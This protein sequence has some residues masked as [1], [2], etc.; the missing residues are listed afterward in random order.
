MPLYEY[1]C[2][3]C[4]GVLETLQR[5][6]DAPLT[7]HENCGGALKKVVSPSA[8]HFKG[9]GWYVTDYAKGSKSQEASPK[10]EVKDVKSDAPKPAAESK[11][12]PAKT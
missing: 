5:L 6:S 11:P 10:P 2:K 12:A 9:K 3:K 4:G 7:V 8:L 1:K